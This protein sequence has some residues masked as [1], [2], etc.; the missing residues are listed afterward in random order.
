MTMKALQL[1]LPVLL[2]AVAFVPLAQ[3]SS[4]MWDVP[5]VDV[6][7]GDL[8]LANPVGAEIMLRR[9]QSAAI[10]VC[11][12]RESSREIRWRTDYRSCVRLAIETAVRKINAPLLTALNEG[13]P[14]TESQLAQGNFLV[15]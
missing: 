8:N 6:S 7:Y 15:R 1:I 4:P 3:A 12:G 11:G 13:R 9:L 5:Q 2:T 14:V 10:Q